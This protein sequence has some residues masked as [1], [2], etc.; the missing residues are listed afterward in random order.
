MTHVICRFVNGE[1]VMDLV[2]GARVE[3]LARLDRA[4]SDSDWTLCWY[5][6]MGTHT[7][8]GL[9]AGE[10]PLQAWCAR[11]HSGWAGWINRGGRRRGLRSRGPILA[12]RPAT[13]MVPDARA[14]VLAAY[15][16]NNP[17]RARVVER[18]ADSEWSSHRAYLGVA[19]SI[20]SLDI[21]RGLRFYGCTASAED[22]ARFGA[23]VDARAADGRDPELSGRTAAQA[24]MR[25]RQRAGV[26]V[27]LAT[28]VLDATCAVYSEVAAPHAYRP[29]I[30]AGTVDRFIE[31]WARLTDTSI[32]SLRTPGRERWRAALRR[33][34]VLAW[35][36]TG[37]RTVEVASALN[38]S[39]ASATNLVRGAT[40]R[41][42]EKAAQA[43]T[44]LG[45]AG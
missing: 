11:V 37:R 26:A 10:E 32:E 1:A 9:I 7:H 13:I 25:A 4:L 35:R 5:C 45:C 18:A 43:A 27:E 40:A 14:G 8:L 30:Y 21:A 42:L 33:S 6:L 12:E 2:E 24:R 39:A 44:T 20:V 34:L 23:F 41:E 3:Y 28:P 17:V 31:S 19:P 36:Y 16:H 22:R 15:I 38:I 29:T